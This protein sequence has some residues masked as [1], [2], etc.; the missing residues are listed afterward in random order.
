ML[1]VTVTFCCCCCCCFFD[2]RSSCLFLGG[3]EKSHEEKKS[4]GMWS[5]QTDV[6]IP[7]LDML[8]RYVHTFVVQSSRHKNDEVRNVGRS[9]CFSIFIQ[10]FHSFIILDVL[11]V[12][13]HQNILLS[14]QQQTT[15]V[16]KQHHQRLRHFITASPV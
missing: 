3:C 16:K 12:V 10:F 7:C 2:C 13:D 8:M 11:L 15:R 5:R 1:V 6:I 14:R 4:S 9:S